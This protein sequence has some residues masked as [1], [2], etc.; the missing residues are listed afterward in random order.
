M[1][2]TPDRIWLDERVAKTMPD[3][4]NKSLAETGVNQVAYIKVTA[5]KA[6]K[7]RLRQDLIKQIPEEFVVQVAITA[8]PLGLVDDEGLPL[9]TKPL[10]IAVTNL[11]RMFQHVEP[12]DWIEIPGPDLDNDEPPF[13]L[14]YT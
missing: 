14:P 3:E 10:V 2:D 11:G 6:D 4:P 12:H 8:V 9:P 13:E 7:D 5:A 1:T